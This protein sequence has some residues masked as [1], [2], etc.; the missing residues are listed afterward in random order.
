MIRKYQFCNKIQQKNL[1]FCKK[2]K[3][4]Q[5][6]VDKHIRMLDNI[7]YIFTIS[8]KHQSTMNKHIISI[9]RQ[10]HLPITIS[11]RFSKF[12]VFYILLNYIFHIYWVKTY[13]YIQLWIIFLENGFALQIYLLSLKTDG[14]S[15]NCVSF[16]LYSSILFTFPNVQ[17]P[18]S[19]SYKNSETADLYI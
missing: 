12:G 14:T 9:N 7:L 4:I 19:L 18:V 11:V 3:Y 5:F 10:K 1:H 13:K 8:T 6:P 17:S 2:C 15:R 16:Y